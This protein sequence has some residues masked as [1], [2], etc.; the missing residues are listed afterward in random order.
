MSLKVNT[1]FNIKA[2]DVETESKSSAN[3]GVGN[4]TVSSGETLYSL[5]KK[6]N[7]K[8]EA[9]IR[10]FLKLSGTQSLKKGQSLSLPTTKLETTVYA[11]ARKYHMTF[12]DLK[13]LNPHI[14][15]FSKLPKGALINVPIRPFAGSSSAASTAKQSDDKK[16][17]Y[18]ASDQHSA[19]S[20]SDS[21]PKPTTPSQVKANNAQRKTQSSKSSVKPTE[22]KAKD[23]EHNQSITSKEIAEKL[24][25]ISKKIGA[26]SSDEFKKT[27]ELINKDNIVEV[28]EEYAKIKGNKE[29]LIE[30]ILS[31]VSNKK[32]DRKK[33]VMKIYDLVAERAGDFVATPE[34]RKAFENELTR[35]LTSWN[36]S[37]F[38]MA[39]SKYLD[40][41]IDELLESFGENSGSTPTSSVSKPTSKNNGK[42]P[43][44]GKS[45]IKKAPSQTKVTVNGHKTNKTIAQVH[46]D[47]ENN[48]ARWKRNVTRP[49]PVTDENGNITAGVTIYEDK[50]VKNGVLSGKTI[51]VNPGHGAAMAN[52]KS[53]FE[54]Q[55]MFDPGSSNAVMNGNV[56]TNEFI[57]NGGKPLEE[58]HVN[59]KFAADLTKQLVSQGAKVIYI[60]GSVYTVPKA[61]RQYRKD[62]DMVVSLHSNSAGNSR[63]IVLIGTD[64]VTGE[65]RTP[66]KADSNFANI[67]Q[68][69]LNENSW[70][71][72]ITNTKTQGLA[73]LRD[74]SNRPYNGPDILIET[75]NLKNEKDVANLNSRQ[76]REYLVEG[77][78]RGI[79][80]CLTG[81]KLSTP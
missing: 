59:S 50:N 33:A 29:S 67:L 47:W 42:L 17:Q 62:A 5:M 70:F 6:L 61:I 51:I 27:F 43:A 15:D 30:M 65:K 36:V 22:V 21:A 31:E 57:G 39:D 52:P 58:W 68:N 41:A 49:E 34:K 9:E 60:T 53:S 56:E 13:A 46:Q 7:F 38:F 1:N 77:I 11:I 73:V 80:R 71:R 8:N 45:M 54:G 79:V 66:D 32:D 76:F 12:N 20:K 35:Q 72:G 10:S 18:K 55:L 69:E 14:K 48:A 78:D 16:S 25:D 23:V 64:L 75:G 26:I 28:L 81:Q 4:Y 44:G 40:K 3:K 2:S 63:G 74:G 37:N 24:R 19:K